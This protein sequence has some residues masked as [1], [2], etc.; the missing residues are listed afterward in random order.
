M[1]KVIK[2][3]L[4]GI[5]PDDD[6]LSINGHRIVD[7]LDIQFHTADVTRLEIKLRRNGKIKRLVARH[8]TTSGKLPLTLED[9]EY[10]RCRNQCFFCFVDGLPDGLR[11]ELY[12]KD[13][14]YRLSFLYGNFITLTN[15]GKP[16]L[17]RI[18]QLRLSPLYVSVHT[19]D[20]RLRSRIFGNEHASEIIPKIETLISANITLHGQIVVIPG[21]NDQLQLEKTID[22][23]FDFFPGFASVGVV[24]VGQTKY[25][26]IALPAI[27]RSYAR[28]LIAQIS[29]IQK[30]IREMT[31]RNFVYL[32]DEFYLKAGVAIPEASHYDDYPQIENGIGMSRI[33]LNQ[34]ANLRPLPKR[35]C[36]ILFITGEIARPLVQALV[37]KLANPKIELRVIKN[38]F[39]GSKI[40]VSGLL[41]GQD[42]QPALCKDY[43]RIVLPPNCINEQGQLLDG[44]TLDELDHDRVIVAPERLSELAKWLT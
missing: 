10:L 40:T 9:P 24:P 42:L 11:S 7:F 12:F 15:I 33:F 5:K 28:R 36:K 31:D 37:A 19:T 14:D 32:A 23:L 13:D 2:S 41:A 34:V 29:S 26:K 21:F 22:D 6:I 8:K 17:V 16:A 1:A 20:P 25:S 18:S 27:D 3:F 44:Y 4:Q 39:L 35:K 43:D 30:T 38:R